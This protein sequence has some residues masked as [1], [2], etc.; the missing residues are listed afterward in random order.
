MGPWAQ[1]TW[2]RAHGPWAYG[3]QGPW[4]L[5]KVSPK[6]DAKVEAWALE[7]AGAKVD[8]KVAFQVLQPGTKKAG[9]CSL[10]GA[11][12]PERRLKN[13]FGGDS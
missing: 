1:G 6:V 5:N 7:T 12:N 11:G 2:P 8:A 13:T 10:P 4:A 3:P 9:T